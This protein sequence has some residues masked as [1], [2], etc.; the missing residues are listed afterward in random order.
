MV[1]FNRKFDV[2]VIGGGNARVMRRDQRAASRR[3]RPRARRR[4][5]VLSWRQH[6]PHAQYALRP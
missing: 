1:D 5:K 2:L 6:A 4:A 3:F